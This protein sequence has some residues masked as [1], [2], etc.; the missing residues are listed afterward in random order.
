MNL[1]RSLRKHSPP[2]IFQSKSLSAVERNYKI[3]NMEML[4]II[5]ALEEWHHYLEGACHPIEI[6]MDHKNL[7]YFHTAQKLNC[8]QAQWSLYLS[9][10]DFLLHH[11]PGCSMGKPDALSWHADHGSGHDDN[12]DMTL[13][14]PELFQIHALSGMNLVGAE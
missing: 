9:H 13:L 6:W 3:H 4:T 8:H 12:C 1:T 11:K 5:Q 10:F 7:E 14:S 2:V